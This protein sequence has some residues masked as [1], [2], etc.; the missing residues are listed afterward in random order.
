M[1]SH[2]RVMVIG[3]SSDLKKGI[4]TYAILKHLYIAKISCAGPNV[5][6]ISLLCL[7]DIHVFLHFRRRR[8]LINNQSQWFREK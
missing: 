7:S 1:F 2:A 6:E 4:C 3:V 5:S 8:L